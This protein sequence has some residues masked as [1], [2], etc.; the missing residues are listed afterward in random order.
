MAIGDGPHR[1]AV[2]LIIDYIRVCPR[3]Y[4]DSERTH[5]YKWALNEA[6]YLLKTDPEPPIKIFER[7]QVKFDSWAHRGKPT[8]YMFGIVATA[9][10]DLIN[11]LLNS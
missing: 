8:D 4:L 5:H 11:L 6:L 7:E 10:D 3:I 2:R 9:Y 1:S